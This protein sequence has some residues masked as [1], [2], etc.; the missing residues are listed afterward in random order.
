MSVHIIHSHYVHASSQAKEERENKISCHSSCIFYQICMKKFWMN[1]SRKITPKMQNVNLLHM[2]EKA[3]NMH[4][5]CHHSALVPRMKL[6]SHSDSGGD[7]PDYMMSHIPYCLHITSLLCVLSALQAND[8]HAF[9]KWHYMTLCKAG[10]GVL[11]HRVKLVLKKN[12]SKVE[13]CWF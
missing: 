2:L 1:D 4:N 11:S 12:C 3:L 9:W 7:S 6:I 8:I 5:H 13:P 10:E